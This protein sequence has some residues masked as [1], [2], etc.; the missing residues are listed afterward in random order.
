MNLPCPRLLAACVVGG[1]LLGGCATGGHAA[2]ERAPRP[3]TPAESLAALERGNARYL[4]GGFESDHAA[5]DRDALAAG[6]A[7]WAAILRCADSRVSPEILFDVE[8]GDLFICA[9]AGNI[10][11]AELAASMEY[12]ILNL[13]TNL[14]VVCGHSN[15]GAVQAA[16][17]YDPDGLPGNLPGLVRAVQS[18]CTSGAEPG[19]AA[20]LA[21][22][23]RCN[24]IRSARSMIEISPVIAEKVASGE[25]GVVAALLELST[26]EVEFIEID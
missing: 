13:Q 24:A 1:T 14:I 25:V 3:S 9:V 19:D 8:K 17:A 22:A 20:D 26:G 5:I 18:D 6:Q 2:R 4:S 12:A 16:I 10:T 15:C 7:P 23:I 21:A 11:T